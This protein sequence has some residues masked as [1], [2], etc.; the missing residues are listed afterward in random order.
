VVVAL[1]VVVVGS[2]VVVVVVG[3]AVV[4]V[5]SVVVVISGV[6]ILIDVV[7]V[8]S[9]GR[10]EVVASTAVFPTTRLLTDDE[11]KLKLSPVHVPPLGLSR[12]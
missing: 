8:D 11:A 1:A 6:R 4:V 5:G 2:T 10:V 12:P 9:G 7:V 3:R